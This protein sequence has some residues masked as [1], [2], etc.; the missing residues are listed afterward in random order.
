MSSCLKNM[1]FMSSCLKNMYF[2]SSC[3]NN[4]STCLHVC[5]SKKHVFMSIEQETSLSSRPLLL[6]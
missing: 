2:M 4:M 1:Y 3:Q 6:R 5:M